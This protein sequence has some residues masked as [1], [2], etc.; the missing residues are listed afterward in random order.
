MRQS[1]MAG[2]LALSVSQLNE[3]VRRLL[4]LDPLLREIELKGEISNLKLHQSGT[5]FFTLKDEQ[6]AVSCVMYAEDV[7]A[8]DMEPFEGMRAV[9]TGSVGLYTRGGQYQF[10]AKKIK[11]Q[12]VGVLYERFLL[13]K[14]R[15]ANEGLFD[16]LKKRQLPGFVDTV[17]VITSPTGAVIHD[18]LNVSTRRD[19]QV[20]VLLCPVRVQGSE[21]ADEIVQAIELMEK[22]E[23]VSI[24]ILARGG[25]SIEDLWTFNEERVVRAVAACRKPIVSAIGHETDYTLCDFA[26]DLRAPTPSAAA[27]CVVPLRDKQISELSRMKH[28]LQQA[29]FSGIEKAQSALLLKK[30]AI[31]S[32]HPQRQIDVEAAK[33]RAMSEQLKRMICERF[34]RERNALSARRMQLKLLSPYEILAR[35]YALVMENGKLLASAAEAETGA[36]IDILMRDGR[37]S[38]QISDV[39]SD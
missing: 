19:E 20:R 5:L 4:Q 39:K 8:L 30:L 25:G 16:P 3:Y 15:L 32:A 12:G 13:L 38:A 36:K 29:V 35:G 28:E 27:E 24:I 31:T 6:A 1:S 7:L 17:G 26:A 11:A 34:D 18:I 10:Y 22:L 9:V 2:K 37:I 33:L 21:A 23:A 14:E